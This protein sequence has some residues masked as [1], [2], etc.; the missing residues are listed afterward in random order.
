MSPRSRPRPINT[1]SAPNCI[2]MAASGGVAMRPAVNSTT[3]SLPA[4]ATS[5]TSS[6]RA[7]SSLAATYS[8]SSGKA[9]SLVGSRQRISGLA[10]VSLSSNERQDKTP[11]SVIP[12]SRTVHCRIHVVRDVALHTG[13]TTIPGGEGMH[14]C[15]WSSAPM[16]ESMRLAVGVLTREVRVFLDKLHPHPFLVRR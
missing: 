9:A 11:I 2:I 12:S 3:G 7:C 10:R 16:P 5:L 6:S 13:T 14:P 15:P 8:S 1:P 4:A